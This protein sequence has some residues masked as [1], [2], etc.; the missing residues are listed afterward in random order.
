MDVLQDLI[1]ITR[2]GEDGYTHAA[3]HVHDRGLRD[4]FSK[5]AR[6]RRSMVAELEKLVQQHLGKS[7]AP[8]QPGH[9]D[10]HR[11][12]LNIRL[13]VTEHDDQAILDEAAAG[14]EIAESVYTAARDRPSLPLPL[15]TAITSLLEKVHRARLRML[16]LQESGIYTSR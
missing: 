16:A 9:A 4:E 6:E 10:V 7:P 13:A 12:W 2:D 3:A 14:E 11:A 8:R 15:R 5:F 1:Y